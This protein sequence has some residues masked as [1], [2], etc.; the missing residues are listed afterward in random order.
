MH[1]MLFVKTARPRLLDQRLG[2]KVKLKLHL[3]WFLWIWCIQHDVQQKNSAQQIKGPYSKATAS[4]I[5]SPRKKIE[6]PSSSAHQ[7][8]NVKIIYSLLYDLSF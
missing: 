3:F 4:C 7:N 5:I 1:R 6:S 8:H 2:R